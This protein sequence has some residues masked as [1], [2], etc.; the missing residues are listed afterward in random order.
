M[1]SS[2]YTQPV[3]PHPAYNQPVQANPTYYQ[4]VQATPTYV[5]PVQARPVYAQPVRATPTYAQP[6]QVR[7]A[8][9]QPVRATP[10]Y[11][12]PVR[13]TP[14]YAQPVQVRPRYVQPTP[15]YNQPSYSQPRQAVV[16][17]Q[18]RSVQAQPATQKVKTRIPMGLV[19]GN[20]FLVKI[21]DGRQVKMTVPAGMRGGQVITIQ[22]GG[23]PQQT[24][25]SRSSTRAPATIAT[26]SNIVNIGASVGGSTNIASSGHTTFILKQ[27]MW[28]L[29]GSFNVF[30]VNDRRTPVYKV[31]GKFQFFDTLDMTM[32]DLA[33]RQPIVRIKKGMHFLSMPKVKIFNPRNQLVC[34]IKQKW[35][36]YTPTFWIHMA[37]GTVLSLN[38]D[39]FSWQYTITHPRLGVVASVSRKWGWTDTY[40]VQITPGQDIPVMIACAV[41]IDKLVTDR[42]K[43]RHRH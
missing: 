9:A 26:R 28:S 10:T 18:A 32:M 17:V 39:F 27:K 16:P 7:P 37:D 36:F 11:A 1:N 33:T 14:T 38:G 24:G 31:K 23:S 20:N 3:Q 19:P 34:T 42:R 40:G 21:P 30:N 15:T 29:G 43:R 35:T 4:P 12:Q 22:V 41:V 8:Y 13:A 6:V 5:Q 2:M 25:S